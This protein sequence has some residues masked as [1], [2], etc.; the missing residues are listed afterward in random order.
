MESYY[1][2]LIV[3]QKSRELVKILYLTTKR[4]PKE[5]TYSLT[6]QIR[7]S[8]VSIP[9]NIAEWSGRWWN[10]EYKR[11]LSIAKWSACELET[12][13]IVANDLWYLPDKEFEEI[14]LRIYEVLKLLSGL[15]KNLPS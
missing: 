14:S 10:T 13:I 6:D 4:F 3:W 5:E 9:S 2:K 1:K 15:I 12:Q 8:V 7:R 11:F